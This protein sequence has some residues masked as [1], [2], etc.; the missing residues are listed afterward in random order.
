MRPEGGSHI[1]Q[2]KRY[3]TKVK[4]IFQNVCSNF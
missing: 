1:S 2:D 3:M 4:D